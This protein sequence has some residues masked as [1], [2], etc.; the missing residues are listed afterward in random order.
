MKE[1]GGENGSKRARQ[2]QLS[3]RVC[4]I[5]VERAD[6]AIP[7]SNHSFVPRV[8]NVDD[9]EEWQNNAFGELGEEKR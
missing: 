5:E 4:R 3:V 6:D 8:T 2:R 9:R 7:E 1:G